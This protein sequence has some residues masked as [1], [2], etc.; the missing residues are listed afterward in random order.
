MEKFITKQTFAAR[1]KFIINKGTRE[2]LLEGFFMSLL[3]K[4]S[5]EDLTRSLLCIYPKRDD[6]TNA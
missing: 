4:F 6:D 1:I 5:I 2:R 3:A